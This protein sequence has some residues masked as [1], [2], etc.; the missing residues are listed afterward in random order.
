MNRNDREHEI[1]VARH[2]N[3]AATWTKLAGIWAA[4]GYRER[5][6]SALAQVIKPKN[7]A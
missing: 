6:Q 1:A 4:L 2:I 5:A 3:Q 7:A